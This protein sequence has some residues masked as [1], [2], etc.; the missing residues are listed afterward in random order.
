MVIIK[1]NVK[2]S[3]YRHAGD[4]GEKIYSSYS[5]FTSALDGGEWS[6]SSPGRALTPGRDPCYPLDRRLG[7]PQ[8]VL[9]RG[10]AGYGT[11]VVQS[12]VRH[13]TD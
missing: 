7:G 9:D 10:S 13:Y 11:P 8:N 2:M 1:A 5:F 4:K 12:V 3:L 6:A